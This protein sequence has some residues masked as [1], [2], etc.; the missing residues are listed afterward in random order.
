M[1]QELK[2]TTHADNELMVEIDSDL[3]NESFTI[4][5]NKTD[6]LNNP[7]LKEYYRTT[8]IDPLVD[9]LKIGRLMDEARTLLKIMTPG[10]LKDILLTGAIQNKIS[11]YNYV[12]AN[13]QAN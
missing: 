1:D 6:K 3:K 4:A 2:K 7:E 12:T 11:S 5:Y 8:I 10:K 13:I 9:Q